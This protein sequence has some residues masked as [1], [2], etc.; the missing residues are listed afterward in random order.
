MRQH[1]EVLEVELEASAGEPVCEVVPFAIDNGEPP[2]AEDAFLA[3][4]AELA[5]TRNHCAH[6]ALALAAAALDAIED[7]DGAWQA[8]RVE[9]WLSAAASARVTI[10][11]AE[12][13]LLARAFVD[14]L[15]D[16][17]RLS[18][19]GQRLLARR[20]ARFHRRAEGAVT[21]GLAA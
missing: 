5:S 18:L 3:D 20:I 2:H 21:H 7:V 4:F 6:A 15:V 16:R 12:L 10:D 1:F 19:H 11:D 17:G 13:C 14:W 9:A 8:L